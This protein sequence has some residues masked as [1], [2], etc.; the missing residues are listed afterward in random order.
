MVVIIILIIII[1]IIYIYIYIYIYFFFFNIRQP[2]LFHTISNTR[3]TAVA[4]LQA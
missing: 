4:A 1:I 2:Y 3:F